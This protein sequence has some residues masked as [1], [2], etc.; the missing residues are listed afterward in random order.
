MKGFL[1]A[2]LIVSNDRVATLD[3]LNNRV[4]INGES[5]SVGESPVDALFV[6]NDLYV[7]ARD[8]NILQRLSDRASV[9]VAA[10]S[11]FL[12]ERSG[13]LYVYSRRGGLLQEIDPRRLAITRRMEVAPFAS[14]LEIAGSTA[15]LV[16]PRDAVIRMIDLKKLERAGEIKAGAVPVDLAITRASNAISGATLS[17][18]DP[19]AKRVWSIEGN[20]SLSAAVARGFIRGLLGLGLFAPQS[21]D[22]PTGVDRVFPGGFAYDSS[23]RTLYRVRNRKV[24]VVAKD[25]APSSL[26]AT[27]RGVVVWKN[28]TLQHLN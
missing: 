7:L 4:T 17:I 5:F 3:G 22:F 13:L 6:G 28:G 21:A 27:E 11:V 26:A 25:L 24:T 1:L 20:Q 2:M 15:Y 10:D 14:D 23:S 19:S 16:Y 18:A 12:R 8:G 9:A